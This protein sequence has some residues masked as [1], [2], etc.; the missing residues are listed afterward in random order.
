MVKGACA[1]MRRILDHRLKHKALIPKGSPQHGPKRR[2]CR[3]RRLLNL[4]GSASKALVS[5]LH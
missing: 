1:P 4:A 5:I 3:Q 2:Q